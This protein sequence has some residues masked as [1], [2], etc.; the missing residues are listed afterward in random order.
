[1][2]PAIWSLLGLAGFTLARVFGSPL[3]LVFLV[4]AIGG[5]VAAHYL[6]SV[7]KAGT[8]LGRLIVWVSTVASLSI[9]ATG[10]IGSRL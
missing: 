7:K 2:A 1:M 8:R 4:A 3:A 5:L 6:I 9:W 10:F